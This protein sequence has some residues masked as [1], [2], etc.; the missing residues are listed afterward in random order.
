MRHHWRAARVVHLCRTGVLSEAQTHGSVRKRVVFVQ[1][2]N[3]V[4][5]VID[6]MHARARGPRAV[7]TR[8]PTEVCFCFFKNK[9]TFV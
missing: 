5:Q 8:Q 7:L 9:N 6:K 1:M 4:L 3:E 2:T